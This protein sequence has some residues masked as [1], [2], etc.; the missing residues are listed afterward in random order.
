MEKRVFSL[1]SVEERHSIIG[2]SVMLG[3]VWGFLL[4]V[5]WRD[6]GYHFGYGGLLLLTF[7]IQSL[8]Y[9][10]NRVRKLEV[11]EQGLVMKSWLRKPVSIDWNL[12]SSVKRGYEVASFRLSK[13]FLSAVIRDVAGKQIAIPGTCRD[14]AE[15]IDILKQ[16]LPDSVFQ[17]R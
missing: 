9:W 16:R 12:V 2:Y 13:R 14:S 5:L 3:L 11:S 6:P 15:I 8:R 10:S 4:S 7:V 17:A 1:S